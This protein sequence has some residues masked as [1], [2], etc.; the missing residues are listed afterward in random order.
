VQHDIGARL[1]GGE[2]DVVD[3]FRIDAN[4]PQR[5]TENAAH[6]GNAYQFPFEHQAESDL[7]PSHSLCSHKSEISHDTPL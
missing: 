5:V 1:G 4:P 3:G 6:D 2:Q 7:R